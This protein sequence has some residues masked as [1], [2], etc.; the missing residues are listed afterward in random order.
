DFWFYWIKPRVETGLETGSNPGLQEHG[1][2]AQNPAM[3]TGS[4]EFSDEQFPAFRPSFLQGSCPVR[5]H[6]TAATQPRCPLSSPLHR[7]SSP[8]K[9]RASAGELRHELRRLRFGTTTNHLNRFFA[10][11]HSKSLEKHTHANNIA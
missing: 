11:F 4:D 3:V 9:N 6:V 2:A 5:L 8:A 7:L 10:G 1:Q